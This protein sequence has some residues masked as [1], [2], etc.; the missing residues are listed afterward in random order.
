MINA[1]F[2]R[3]LEDVHVDDLWFHQGDATSA[4]MA[5]NFWWAPCI[6]WCDPKPLDYLFWGYVKSLVYADKPKTINVLKENMRRFIADPQPQL[7]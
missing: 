4:G 1:F 3:E 2:V 7:L 5:E 6:A